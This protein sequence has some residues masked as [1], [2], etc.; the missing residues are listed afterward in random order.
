MLVGAAYEYHI[1]AFG[2]Q[3]ADVY[4]AGQVATGEVADVDGAIGIDQSGSNGVSFVVLLSH[5][6]GFG[7]QR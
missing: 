3:V 5:S 7:L 6:V 4:I 2:A 1:L